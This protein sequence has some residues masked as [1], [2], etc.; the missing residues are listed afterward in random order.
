MLLGYKAYYDKLYNAWV[1]PENVKWRMS[2]RVETTNFHTTIQYRYDAMVHKPS[3][4]L[5][6]PK[7]KKWEKIWER[8]KW[9]ENN[10]KEDVQKLNAKAFQNS[11]QM[12]SW[13]QCPHSGTCHTYAQCNQ[14]FPSRKNMAL[15]LTTQKLQFCRIL[16]KI[17]PI[18]DPPIRFHHY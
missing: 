17:N 6:T 2:G 10:A 13:F 4:L 18:K 14:T 3:T 12:L 5:Q 11:K 16:S 15:P 8:I 9:K 1:L 7:G